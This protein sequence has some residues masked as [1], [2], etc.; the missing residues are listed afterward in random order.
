MKIV[1]RAF[2]YH[3]QIIHITCMDRV[4]QLDFANFCLVQPGADILLMH[5]SNCNILCLQ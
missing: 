5:S 2:A 3:A 1:C 4:Q